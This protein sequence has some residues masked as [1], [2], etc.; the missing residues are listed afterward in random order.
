MFVRWPGRLAVLPV[1][2]RRDV[3]GTKHAFG[4]RFRASSVLLFRVND[5]ERA[6][7]VL[8]CS[9]DDGLGLPGSF[10]LY[11]T[12]VVR[13]PS[14]AVVAVKGC[15]FAIPG[16]GLPMPL[17]RR[18]GIPVPGTEQHMRARECNCTSTRYRTVHAG[19]G[20]QLSN[21]GVAYWARRI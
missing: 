7:H 5:S 13:V 21:R 12:C 2:R 18:S 16:F 14:F 3:G 15:V 8:A 10:A 19:A 20:V 11:S 4:A 1:Q 17:S 6:L 9:A